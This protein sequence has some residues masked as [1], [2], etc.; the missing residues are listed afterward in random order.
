MTTE[1]PAIIAL[2]NAGW[3]PT[4][5]VDISK[6]IAALTREGVPQFKAIVDFLREYSGLVIN[7]DRAGEPDEIWFSG[8]RASELMAPDW[9]EDY[10]Q[11][12]GVQLAPVGAAYGEYLTL[13]IAEDGSW[14]G[15]FDDEFGSMGNNFLDTLENILLN[16]GFVARFD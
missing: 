12:S 14:Y 5:S 9:I 1:R 15:G 8:E 16:K 2:K 10:S 13:L 11:R 7:F 6:D 3:S 4:R